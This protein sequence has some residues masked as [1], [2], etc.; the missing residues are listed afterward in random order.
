M[1]TELKIGD[2]VLCVEGVCF[3]EHSVCVTG[4][5]YEIDGIEFHDTENAAEHVHIKGHLEQDW[6]YASRFVLA[7]SA[8]K[9]KKC[10]ICGSEGCMSTHGLRHG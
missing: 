8:V 4:E 2:K 3:N 7:T 6:L 9:T 10:S 1:M 5:E